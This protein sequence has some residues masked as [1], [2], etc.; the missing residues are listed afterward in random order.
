MN[1]I[2][3]QLSE[4]KSIRQFTGEFVKDEDLELIIKTAQRCPTSINGQQI[5]LIYTKDKEKIKQI[6]QL[7]GGQEQIATA[8]VFI[9]ICVDFNRTIFAVEQTGEKHQIDKSAE[10]VLVGAVDAGIMLNA[11]QITAES[12][13]YGTTAIGAVRNEPAKMIELL[14]LPLKTFP[15][16]GT[17][18]GVPTLEAKNAP[19]K[20][21]I[22]LESFAFEDNY[23]DKKVKDGVLVYEKQMKKFREDNNMN[24][25][26]SYCEQTANYYKNIYFRKIEENYTKQGF[27]FKD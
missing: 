7:C 3:K 2:I 19:L 4:R 27:I 16:V 23:D 12:L 20:P 14:N 21:R 11:I 13:G 5:S 15:I 25:L 26:Q 18:I 9:T 22:P 10:G 1:P 17:T 8:D 6:A 24:Y